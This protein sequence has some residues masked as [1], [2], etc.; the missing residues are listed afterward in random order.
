MRWLRSASL[1]REWSRSFKRPSTTWA[2][3][4]LR[5][6]GRSTFR[7]RATR[8]HLRPL[9]A[10]Q[11]RPTVDDNQEQQEPFDAV[12]LEEIV[13]CN[14]ATRFGMSKALYKQ[15]RKDH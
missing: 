8:S 11:K 12:V 10:P 3:C 4:W 13:C 9:G 7:T 14:C 1:T 2:K 15:R 6:L 5:F